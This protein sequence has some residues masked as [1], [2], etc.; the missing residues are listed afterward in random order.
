MSRPGVSDDTF[1]SDGSPFR[2]FYLWRMEDE[3]G[4]SRTGRVLEGVLTQSGEVIVQ[5]RPPLTST[6]IYKDFDTFMAIHVECHPSKNEV[7][8][9]D[10]APPSEAE[11]EKE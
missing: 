11:K 1:R 7:R 9:V 4:I 3:T 5:W 6:A 8:W 2:R 10:P